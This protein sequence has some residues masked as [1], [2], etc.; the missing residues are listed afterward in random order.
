MQFVR[1]DSF[2]G[3]GWMLNTL[4][5]F[6]CLSK[7]RVTNL[8]PVKIQL[9]K[10]LSSIMEVKKK[11]SV[12]VIGSYDRMFSYKH[13]MILFHEMDS[14]KPRQRLYFSSYFCIQVWTCALRMSRRMN[15]SICTLLMGLLQRTQSVTPI[16]LIVWISDNVTVVNL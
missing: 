2:F 1:K 4:C 16:H 9:M 5:Q 15:R 11:K 3:L 14:W 13:S 12:C 6:L 7:Y 8:N 10:L